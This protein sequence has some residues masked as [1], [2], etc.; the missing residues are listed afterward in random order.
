MAFFS[1]LLLLFGLKNL[2]HSFTSFRQG[3][4]RGEGRLMWSLV[5]PS[6]LLRPPS[7]SL[8]FPSNFVLDVQQLWTCGAALG[9]DRE[10][11]A[12]F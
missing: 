4:K 6:C 1:L 5:V 9:D 7:S 2:R 11:Y 3:G 10:V 12:A 8:L